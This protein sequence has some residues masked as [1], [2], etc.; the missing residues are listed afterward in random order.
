VN[1]FINREYRVQTT[2]S[3]RETPSNLRVSASPILLRYFVF[4]TA[5]G[6]ITSPDSYGWNPPNPL[7]L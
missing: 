4:L 2:I 1:I 3:L 7:I 5:I 6:T